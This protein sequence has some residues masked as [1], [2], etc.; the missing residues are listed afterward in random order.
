MNDYYA[1]EQQLKAAERLASSAIKAVIV[2]AV[3]NL[4]LLTGIISGGWL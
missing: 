3:V 4:I 1:L 2:L